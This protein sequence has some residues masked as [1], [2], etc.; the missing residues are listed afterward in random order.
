MASAMS[1]MPAVGL[2]RL[3]RSLRNRPQ[4]WGSYLPALPVAAWI[5]TF[6][7]G[8]E[9]LGYLLGPGRSREQFR[10][11]ALAIERDV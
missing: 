8:C 6:I 3:A 1:A 2:F 11:R 9:A 4:L 10:A 5:Y 7:A